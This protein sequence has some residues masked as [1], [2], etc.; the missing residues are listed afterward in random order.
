[1]W[2]LRTPCARANHESTFAYFLKRGI[3]LARCREAF[4]QYI[5]QDVFYLQGFAKAYALALAKAD[6]LDDEHFRVL[7]DLL[8]GVQREVQLHKGF[9]VEWGLDPEGVAGPN[10]ATTAYI[11]F[12]LAV[13]EGSKA[14]A[15]TGSS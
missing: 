5:A 8:R 9:L 4:Q 13:A 12:L 14:S 11:D 10:A 7:S 15:S 2:P 3:S 1:M 6:S